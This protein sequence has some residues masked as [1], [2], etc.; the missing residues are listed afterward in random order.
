[1][2]KLNIIDEVVFTYDDISTGVRLVG[3]K[4]YDYY[5][6]EIKTEEVNV[7][8]MLQGGAIFAADLF[9]EKELGFESSKVK[10][11]IHYINANSYYGA[12]EPSGNVLVDLCRVIPEDNIKNKDILIVDDIY[13][14]GNTLSEVVERLK[15]YNP[16]SLECCVLLNREI[17]KEK[18]V[19]VKF[20]ALKTE[21]T[22]FFI[23]YG[24]D[25]AGK[26]RELPH[27]VTFNGDIETGEPFEQILCNCC[28]ES[29]EIKIHDDKCRFGLI[30][31][32][33]K[34]GY[35]SPVLDDL[36]VY[37]FDICEGCL[38]KMFEQF[39]IPVTMA[40]YDV[41]TVK[42]DCNI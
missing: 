22:E 32:K 33:V 9:S 16:K 28:G 19:D 42:D 2:K 4:I 25:Y 30:N 3:R 29:C 10:F 40:E 15:K 20:I 21:R 27:I 12:T 26:Y 37:R 34:G 8:V 18:E 7:F 6:R 11:K 17:E 41:W 39:K 5:T 36:M 35:F 38:K 31:A 23:G 24:L 13:D 14:R 1:M